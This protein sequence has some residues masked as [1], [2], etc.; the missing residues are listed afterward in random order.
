MDNPDEPGLV[1][2]LDLDNFKRLNDV[3]GHI[4]GD[5]FL[6]KVA[7]KLKQFCRSTDIISRLGGDEFMI[8]MPNVKEHEIQP[9]V[10]R[11]ISGIRKEYC[12]SGVTFEVTASVGIAHYPENGR[13]FSELYHCAD[14]AL[15]DA[16]R[17]GKNCYSQYQSTT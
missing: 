13:F 8:F 2:L 1:L 11:I 9:L 15:Y 7:E 10:S 6:I 5:N 14:L 3:C 12:K 17:N 4:E 16:K